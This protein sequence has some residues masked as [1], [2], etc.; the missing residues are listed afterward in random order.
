MVVV[1]PTSHTQ[2]LDLGMKTTE[3]DWVNIVEVRVL[4][5]DLKFDWILAQ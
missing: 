2:L 3:V 1:V 5:L 4:G